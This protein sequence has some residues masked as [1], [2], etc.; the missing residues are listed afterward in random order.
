ML[1]FLALIPSYS[2][3]GLWSFIVF[4][5][6]RLIQ[7]DAFGFELGFTINYSNMNFSQTNK[8]FIYYF[9]LLSGEMGL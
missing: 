2:Q 4:W 9:I 5:V 1:F 3:I 6:L 7:G 8:R